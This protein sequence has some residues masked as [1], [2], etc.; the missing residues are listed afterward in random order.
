ML[1]GMSM[2]K[3]IPAACVLIVLSLFVVFYSL[4][5]GPNDPNRPPGPPRGFFALNKTAAGV[6]PWKAFT[7]LHKKFGSV[8]SLYQGKTLVVVLGTVKAATDLL[9]KRGS[10]YSSR[11]R[12][13]MASELMSGGMRGLTMPYGNRWRGWRS[14]MHAGMGIEASN[15]YK[16]LQS[17]ESKILLRDLLTETDLTRYAAHLRRFAISIVYCITYG[18]RVTSL[19]DPLV[20]ANHKT[21]ESALISMS[22]RYN[23]IA[24]FRLHNVR[25]AKYFILRLIRIGFTIMPPATGKYIVESW[26]FLLK[27]PH[28]LQWFR[29]APLRQR[30][31]DSKLYL[32]LMNTVHKQME[33]GAAPQSIARRAIERQK[34]FGLNDLETAFALS[35]PFTAGV[36]TTLAALDVFFLAMLHYPAVMHRAQEEIE[37]VVGKDRLP[38]F[39]DA[40]S[41]PYINAMIKEVLRWR[42]IAPLGVAH[43]VIADDTYQDMSIP[44]GSTVFANIYSMSKGEEMF[45]SPDDFDPER[46]LEPSHQGEASPH[47]TFFFGFGR[48]IC[49]GMH[50]A[51]NSLFIVIARILSAFNIQLPKGSALPSKVSEDF[52]GGL[53]IRPKPFVYQLEPRDKS[54]SSPGHVDIGILV[55][56]EYR[57][58]LDEA[59]GWM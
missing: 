39:D 16:T 55:E 2:T 24:I 4:V 27:L 25:R 52:I 7:Q 10:I 31:S 26:P 18:R 11:P 29:H 47:S 20:V 46:Y 57:R 35:A 30:A 58:A 14:L 21:D 8:V 9:D 13:I 12:N 3:F 19:D 51:H 49:P 23:L 56:E 42:P 45:P 22:I 33:S 41:L 54:V 50:V 36:G 5:L 34:E 17:I 43:S 37:A 28:F 59:K 1:N 6:P 38:E 48:R 32:Y 53:V 40:K 44:N 15:G